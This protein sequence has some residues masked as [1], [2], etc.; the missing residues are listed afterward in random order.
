MPGAAVS[1]S[2]RSASGVTET[3]TAA[4][5]SRVFGSTVVDDAEALFTSVPASSAVT[6][7]VTFATRP[8]SSAP[9]VQCDV[10]SPTHEPGVAVDETIDAP[11]GSVS[12]SLTAAAR[13][14]PAFR[15]VAVYLSSSPIR[16]AAGVA[17]S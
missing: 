6:T 5:L 15:I 16:T 3:L 17:T 4:L 1:V 7:I 14:G 2:E 9:S 12:S 13:L 11:A 8:G 10:T